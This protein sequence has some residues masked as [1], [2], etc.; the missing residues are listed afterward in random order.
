MTGGHH[1][2]REANAVRA[3]PHHTESERQRGRI[4]VLYRST[5]SFS[6]ERNRAGK[7]EGERGRERERERERERTG[8]ILISSFE[9]R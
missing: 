3:R 7:R 2:D 8:W 6:V 5:R 1:G 9:T 4:K